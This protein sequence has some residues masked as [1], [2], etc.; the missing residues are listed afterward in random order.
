MSRDKPEPSL[1]NQF[2]PEIALLIT[3]SYKNLTGKELLGEV[4]SVNVGQCL[5]EAPLVV[6]AHDPSPEPIFFYANLKA[7][8]IFEMDWTSLT[9]LPSKYSAEPINQ[10]ERIRLLD[11]VNK[12]GFIDHY[13]GI[14]ISR[15]ADADNETSI[16]CH[17]QKSKMDRA[18]RDF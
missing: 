16:P 5:Y 14:R 18:F 6:L 10:V 7:Q 17:H 3:Q 8:E 12:N 9:K 13:S 15:T 4:N 2:L 11:Q 1:A